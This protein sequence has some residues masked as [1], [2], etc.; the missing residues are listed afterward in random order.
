VDSGVQR[1]PDQIPAVIE[2]ILDNSS[3]I[4]IGLRFL[5]DSDRQKVP[6]NRSSGIKTITKVDQF[7]SY[8]EIS[9][10]QSGFR[11]C[12]KRARPSISIPGCNY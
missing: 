12:G 1:D 11:A 8:S 3:D 4:V 9:D 10:A 2:P 6:K 7:A 5:T